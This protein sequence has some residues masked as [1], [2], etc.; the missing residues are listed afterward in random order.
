MAGSQPGR[1]GIHAAHRIGYGVRP[2]NECAF[3]A[4]V[5]DT[6]KSVM[7]MAKAAVAHFGPTLCPVIHTLA[8][9]KSDNQAE[10]LCHSVFLE[11]FEW[12]SFGDVWGEVSRESPSEACCK[13]I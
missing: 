6:A 1:L 12:A 3:S 8:S 9:A 11:I 13:S 10:E 5:E 4:E 7:E 2:L